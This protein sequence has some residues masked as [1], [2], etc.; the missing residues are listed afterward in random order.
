MIR[1]ISKRLEIACESSPLLV[2]RERVGDGVGFVARF[3]S[4]VK[5][6]QAIARGDENIVGIFDKSRLERFKTLAREWGETNGN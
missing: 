2:T 4:T 5:S 3:A 6:Q 1:T